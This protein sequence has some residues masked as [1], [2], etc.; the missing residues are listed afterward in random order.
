MKKYDS[1]LFDLDGTLTDSGP[2]I[3]RCGRQALTELG[4]PFDPSFETL[5]IFVGPPLVYSF[6]KFGVPPE[7][8]DEAIRIYRYH[9]NFEG[10]KLE[11]IPYE[12]IRELLETLVSE[13][14]DLYVATSKTEELAIELLEGF[15]LAS[16]FR[17]IAGATQGHSRENK[18][19]VIRY[20]LGRIGDPGRVV[21][22]GDTVFDVKGARDLNLP[23]I[24]VSWGYGDVAEMRAAGAVGIADSMEDLHRLLH[25]RQE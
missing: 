16:Y 18:N 11:N 1:V 19:D 3:M 9:Y 4:I 17:V 20:L 22:V 2:G 15:G 25:V 13:G 5:R 14:Y 12:G 8:I 23:C 6:T 7:Q 10:G 24:G 21:M